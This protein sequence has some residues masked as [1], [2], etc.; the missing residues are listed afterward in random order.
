MLKTLNKTPK[1]LRSKRFPKQTIPNVF[2]ISRWNPLYA[3][4]KARSY[5]LLDTQE[6]VV[7]GVWKTTHMKTKSEQKIP[8]DLSFTHEVKISLQPQKA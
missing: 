4:E 8:L 3:H 1:N 6:S 2:I 5:S 7:N